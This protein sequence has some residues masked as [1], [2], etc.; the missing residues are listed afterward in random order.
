MTRKTRFFLSLGIA[1][2]LILSLVVIHFS[3]M[4]QPG[5]IW[6]QKPI[7]GSVI[8][9][10]SITLK[11]RAYS[12]TFIPLDRIEVTYEFGGNWYKDQDCVFKPTT[13][14]DYTCILDFKKL[15]IPLGRRVHISFDVYGIL[16]KI[17]WIGTLLVN[18]NLSPNGEDCF[19]WKQ[20]DLHNPC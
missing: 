15:G 8:Q 16:M 10:N 14:K 3:K 19:Y 13:N 5:G 17:P 18:Y 20:S 7:S 12:N 2:I 6:L 9:E 4:I 1:L 11:I